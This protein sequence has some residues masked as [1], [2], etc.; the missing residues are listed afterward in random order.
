MSTSDW[1]ATLGVSLLLLAFFMNQRGLLDENS[2]GYLLL[3][4]FGASIAGFA[5]WMAGIIPFVVLEGV[6]ALV[7][8]WGLL[9]RFAS[10]G[11]RT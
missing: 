8:G 1:I 4:F 2:Q 6:W 11:G 9:R 10:A 7:A 3:N 5:A